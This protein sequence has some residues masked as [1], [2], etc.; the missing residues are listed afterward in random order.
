MYKMNVLVVTCVLMLGYFAP[1]TMTAPADLG[2][3]LCFMQIRDIPH[4]IFIAFIFCGNKLY[5][6]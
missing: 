1:I 6:K 2:V 3:K 4:M 5:C